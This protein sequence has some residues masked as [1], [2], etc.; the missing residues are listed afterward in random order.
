[1][2]P[3]AINGITCKY[4]WEEG[5]CGI[6]TEHGVFETLAFRTSMIPGIAITY[7]GVGRWT[8]TLE[9]SGMSLTG[10]FRMLYTAIRVAENFCADFKWFKVKPTPNGQPPK[11]LKKVVDE[12][13][14]AAEKE[15]AE[16]DAMGE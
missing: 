14:W 4:R 2:I 3:P 5:V 15:A 7:A 8:I 11:Q 16:L 13:Y 1:M 10:T 12:I 6:L 9:A